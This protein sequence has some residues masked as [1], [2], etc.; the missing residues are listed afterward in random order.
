MINKRWLKTK[1]TELPGALPLGPPPELCP[2][3]TGGSTALCKPP[4]NFFMSLVLKK[5]FSLLQTQSGTQ[6]Q[7]WW[8][9]KVLGK[10]LEAS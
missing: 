2:G 4:A 3:L 5:G 8:Y 6:K 10:T 9:D 1:Y 7:K